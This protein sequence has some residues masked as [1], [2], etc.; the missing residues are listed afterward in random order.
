MEE[1]DGPSEV[2]INR[3]KSSTSE[4]FAWIERRNFE[5]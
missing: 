4:I 3:G 5:R 1:S 2:E